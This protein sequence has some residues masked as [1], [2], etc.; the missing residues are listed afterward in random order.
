MTHLGSLGFPYRVVGTVVNI[1][2]LKQNTIQD[3]AMRLLDGACR[4]LFGEALNPCCLTADQFLPHNVLHGTTYS[5]FIIPLNENNF[6][7]YYH[8]HQTVTLKVRP[9]GIILHGLC[10]KGIIDSYFL[11]THFFLCS[12]N[13]IYRI[14]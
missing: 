12:D 7:S 9:V 3:D 10:V 1:I 4:M 2:P 13:T 6:H 8:F 11:L 14:L 5:I